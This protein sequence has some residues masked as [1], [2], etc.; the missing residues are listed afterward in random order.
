[1]LIQEPV[2]TLLPGFGTEPG[3]CFSTRLQFKPRP[4]SLELDIYLT[5][6]V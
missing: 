5:E 4:V 6:A 3:L 1:M 2:F